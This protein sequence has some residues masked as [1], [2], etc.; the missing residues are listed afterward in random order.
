MKLFVFLKNILIVVNLPLSAKSLW[1]SQ[2]YH[3]FFLLR[4]FR[5]GWS[6][7]LTTSPK[8]LLESWSRKVSVYSNFLPLTRKCVHIPDLFS[9]IHFKQA[10]GFLVRLL[11]WVL[12]ITVENTLLGCLALFLS[13]HLLAVLQ[14][15]YLKKSM[16]NRQPHNTK[17]N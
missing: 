6:G 1:K 5:L 7:V 16:R 17:T 13:I 12:L 4:C 3:I 15:Y 14:N 2:G 11:I 8:L 10:V 9:L